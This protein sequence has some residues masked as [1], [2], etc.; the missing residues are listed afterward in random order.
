MQRVL[1]GNVKPVRRGES[2]GGRAPVLL[3]MVMAPL[4]LSACEPSAGGAAADSGPAELDH[5]RFRPV[6]LAGEA[7][8]DG[9]ALALPGRIEVVGDALVLIDDAA[10]LVIRVHDRASGRK[11]GAFGRSGAGPG[12]FRGAWSIDPV[13]GRPGEFW[14]FDLGLRRL[15]H[16]DLERDLPGGRAPGD[17]P[18]LQLSAETALLGPV[19][20]GAGRV[21]LGFFQEG[22]LGRLDEAGRLV[23]VSGRLPPDERDVPATVLQHAY[24]STLKPNPSRTRFA[25]AT[26]HADR[27][28]ILDLH[29][30]LLALAEP[31]FGFVPQFEVRDRNGMAAM[32]S[33]GSLRFGYIDVATTEDRIYALFSGRTRRGFP[34]RANFGEYVH[35]FDWGGTLLQ[36]LKLDA[37]ALAI[38]A[39]TE[40]FLYTVRHEPLPAVM[41]YVLPAEP[42][43]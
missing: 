36:V 2:R 32:A 8:T 34:G 10:E 30:T 9:D 22:R 42:G 41:R 16:Y 7:L 39:D 29:G 20:A 19:L 24:Q 13:P 33:G 26:R 4:L 27:L 5:T 37:E 43:Q 3:G 17:Q 28:E 40:G 14:V 31:P 15:T 6:A 21:S 18:M 38:T 25:V 12:E 11:L 1:A 35:V 23:G